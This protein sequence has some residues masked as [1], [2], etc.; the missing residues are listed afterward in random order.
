MRCD[1]DE[2]SYLRNWWN[3]ELQ[4]Q[5]WHVLGEVQVLLRL[6]LALVGVSRSA[7]LSD[8]RV[9]FIVLMYFVVL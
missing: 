6:N 8:Q 9:H 5:R 4:A 3:G 2:V 7:V 1:G